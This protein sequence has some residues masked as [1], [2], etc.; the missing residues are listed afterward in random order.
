MIHSGEC[1]ACSTTGLRRGKNIDAPSTDDNYRNRR[2]MKIKNTNQ[3]TNYDL[4]LASL[5]YITLQLQL[6]NKCT[7]RHVTSRAQHHYH[8]HNTSR[9]SHKFGCHVTVTVESRHITVD[10]QLNRHVLCHDGWQVAV[11][12]SHGKPYFRSFV[13]FFLFWQ[14]RT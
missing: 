4:R 2:A 9:R 12:S 10:L 11:Q 8:R 13:F 1:S 6:H 14:I 3:F 7:L 5:H